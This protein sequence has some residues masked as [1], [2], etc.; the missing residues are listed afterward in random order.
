MKP[1]PGGEDP[2]LATTEGTPSGAEPTMQEELAAW[3]RVILLETRGRHTGQPV[4]AAVGFVEEPDGSFLV[5]AG[6]DAAWA[7]NLLAD[8]RCRVT[9]EGTVREAVA[10]RLEGPEHQR[11]IAAL[12]LRYGTPAERLGRGPSFRLRPG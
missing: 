2:A 4:V 6:D 5:A 9:L 1:P 7:R 10:E 8:G 3:G 12:I 11:A